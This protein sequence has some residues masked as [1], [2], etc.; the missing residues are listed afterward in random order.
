MGCHRYNLETFIILPLC[1]FP[2]GQKSKSC[3]QPLLHG[4][5]T[6]H[7]AI[8]IRI[9]FDNE[10][11]N[12]FRNAEALILKRI[13]FLALIAAYPHSTRLITFRTDIK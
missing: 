2:I 3:V 11:A 8:V 6:T 12:Q 1:Y 10:T 4:Q 5:H 7:G 13:F 9:I